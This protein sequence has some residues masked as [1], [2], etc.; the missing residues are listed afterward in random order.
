MIEARL[1]SAFA[2]VL[3]APASQ[4]GLS[5]FGT[6]TERRQAAFPSDCCT[7]AMTKASKLCQD[8]GQWRPAA[9]STHSTSL[10]CCIGLPK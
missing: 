8:I 7:K 3:E 9:L 10:P 6:L 5:L 2:R 4:P 1:P